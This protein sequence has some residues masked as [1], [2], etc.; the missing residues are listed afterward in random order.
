[1]NG[2]RGCQSIT[3]RP[4]QALCAICSV[5]KGGSVPN[6]G[7]IE[8]LLDAVRKNPDTPVTLRCNVGDVFSFQDPG[9]EDD[10]PEGAEFNR[11]RD[12]E[13][14]MRLNFVPG[15]T[16]TAR[17]LF[18]R[19]LDRI[20]TVSGI[21]CYD[22]S[23]S[24]SDAWKGCPM[25]RSGNYER[26]RKAGINAIIAPRSGEELERE[27]EESLRAMHAARRTGIRVRPHILV[28]S[29]CQYGSGVRPPYREDNLPELLQ[30]ALK[31]PDTL[32]TMAEGAD[33]MMCA[34]CP[35]R[36]PGLNACGNVK[37]SGGGT[38][39]LRDLRTLQKLGLTYGATLKAGELYR[40]IFERIPST[41]DICRF[42]SPSPSVWWDDCGAR[43]KNNESYA[44][45]REALMREFSRQSP[46]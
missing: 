25:A 40:L 42:E 11:R 35:N 22:S 6:N 32:V 36:A 7:K 9:T 46:K 41:L 3:I 39:Q 2:G 16:V 43:T 28:C 8:R 30:L 33:W 18:N 15:E 14:L 12:L 20:E 38:N 44:K 13:I 27:K 37:G 45:G 10:T 29:V 26:G 24:G 19:L 34:P 23:G 21:C 4:Y 31:E 5:G 1:M 17:I